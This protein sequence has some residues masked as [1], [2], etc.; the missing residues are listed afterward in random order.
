L[1]TFKSFALSLENINE[2]NF[3]DIV[4]SVFRFQSSSNLVYSN[5]LRYLNRKVE[6]INDPTQI[7]FLPISFFKTQVI[8]SGSWIPETEF[9]SSG[10]TGTIS[11]KHQVYS[12]K[13]YQ[14]IAE[15]I[16]TNFFGRLDTFHFLALLP[17]YLERKGS[18]LIEMMN[19]FIQRSNSEHSGFYLYNHEDLIDK[20][21]NLKSDSRKTILWGVSF[22]LLD[23][24]EKYEVDLSH[25]QIFETGGMKG[26][27]QEIIHEEL[28]K[29][30]KSRF[31]VDV[32]YSE[33]GM[34]ELMSQAYSDSSGYFKTP[35]WMKIFVRNIND[36]FEWVGPGKN[37]GI[38]VIDL[39]NFHSCSFIETQ[40]IGS[41]DLNGH[42]EILGRMDN[43]DIRGCNLLVG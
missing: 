35:P 32:I 22:A 41:V 36:P 1:D 14:E 26:R 12:I 11:S 5:Y 17:S 18:S 10:T 2:G 42:F 15:R 30:L 43:S 23:L 20:L 33:Y 6:D 21:I 24:A 40:D 31:N 25:C 16:F 4:M 3:N 28:H 13:Y 8:K 34:T 19:Y 39:A 37:G 38:N 9:Y 7:P 29:I 27:R